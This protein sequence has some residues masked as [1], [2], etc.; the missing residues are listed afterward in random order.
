MEGAKLPHVGRL[1][2]LLPTPV[3]SGITSDTITRP[4]DDKSAANR[5]DV[6]DIRSSD[7]SVLS[8]IR[9]IAQTPKS[10]VSWVDRVSEQ[11]GSVGRDDLRHSVY[12]LL[13]KCFDAPHFFPATA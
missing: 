13:I 8:A 11:D 9:I 7:P 10:A 3:M 1:L 6:G 2:G 12:L 4:A 5:R